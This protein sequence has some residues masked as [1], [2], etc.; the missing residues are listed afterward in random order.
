MSG[1]RNQ[2]STACGA[3]DL[4]GEEHF[5]LADSETISQTT[6]TVQNLSGLLKLSAGD[7][8]KLQV[9]NAN[10]TAGGVFGNAA[11]GLPALSMAWVGPPGT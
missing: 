11:A 1:G 8:V 3:T 5:L 2:G 6:N 4:L 9:F 7:T 10:S